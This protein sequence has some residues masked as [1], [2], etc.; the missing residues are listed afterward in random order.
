MEPKK[1]TSKEEEEERLHQFRNDFRNSSKFSNILDTLIEYADDEV[2]SDIL[3]LK[4]TQYLD[5]INSYLKNKL[6]EIYTKSIFDNNS[7]NN[8]ISNKIEKVKKNYNSNFKLLNDAYEFFNNLPKKNLT[9]Y[10]LTDFRKHCYDT[11]EYCLHSCHSRIKNNLL[12]VKENKKYLICISCK[13]VYLNTF[14]DGYCNSCSVEYKTSILNKNEN[15]MLLPATWKKYHCEEII[16]EKIKCIK[17]TKLLYLN[18]KTQNLDCLNCEFSA[19]PNRIL[20]TCNI[21]K[22]EFKSDAIVY[23]PLQVEIVKKSINLTLMIKHKAHP[24]NLSCCPKINVYFQDFYHKKECKGILYLGELRNKLIIVCEKCKSINFYE[25]FIWTCPNC[26]RRFRDRKSNFRT[27]KDLV[28]N[29]RQNTIEED[30]SKE[31][32]EDKKEKSYRDRLRERR[33]RIHNRINEEDDNKL[34]KSTT[35][36]EGRHVRRSFMN[37]NKSVDQL[38]GKD[39]EDDSNNRTKNRYNR[40]NHH[41]TQEIDE[42]DSK[43]K[44]HISGRYKNSYRSVNTEID[45]D[46]EDNKKFPS[47]TRNKRFSYFFLE[48]EKENKRKKE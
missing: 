8:L 9:D 24:N 48:K 3:N 42:N 37:V 30:N 20:W 27:Y 23:N 5:S 2:F 25:R 47:S 31:E 38:Y 46:E 4:E 34:N 17:C 33:E 1:K 43:I 26:G 11:Q 19:K 40:L 41:Q 10:Y 15:K 21:D 12:V 39:D 22:V 7:L 18:F 6:T 13:K 36:S 32:E 16:N 44:S 29:D 28:N 14:I 45:E 35:F